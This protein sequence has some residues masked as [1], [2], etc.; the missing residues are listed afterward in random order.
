MREYFLSLS[1]LSASTVGVAHYV[2]RNIL[3]A[4]YE[5]GHISTDLSLICEKPRTFAGSKIPSAY[6]PEDIQALLD[7]VDRENP[8]GKRDYAILLLGACLGLRASDIRTTAF[9]NLRW[10][11][12]EIRIIQEKTNNE[13]ALPLSDEIGWAIIDYLKNGRPLTDS[14]YLFVRHCAP[15]EP[16]GPTNS[17]GAII[18]K[19]FRRANV[20]IP[21]GKKHGM[22]ILR[23]SLANN[24]LAAGIPLPILTEA[25][26]HADSKTTM[27]Y[28]KVDI[29]QLRGCALE[30]EIG[31]DC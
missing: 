24:M 28:I 21:E 31:G 16:F 20:R 10:D 9:E 25:L 2:L 6:P 30:T 26:D 22:H 12:H 27:Q 19:Y 8:T 18:G 13:L 4:A 15:Y 14:K 17:L 5:D 29:P 7:S 1:Y 23:H 3:C 11:S